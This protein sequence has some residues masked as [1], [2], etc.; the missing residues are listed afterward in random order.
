MFSNKHLPA[1]LLGLLVGTSPALEAQIS[2]PTFMAPR[3][4]N[5][6]GAYL[7]NPGLGQLAIEGIWRRNQGSYD[8]GLRGGLVDT[9]DDAAVTLGIEF[10]NPFVLGE[11]PV[12][13][14]LTAGAQGLIGD[15]QR[16]GAQVG[17]SVGATFYPEG[18]PFSLTPYL[19]PRLAVVS[20]LRDGDGTDVNVLADLGVDFEFAPNVSLRLG[21][22]V[23]DESSSFGFGFAVR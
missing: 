3:S 23:G 8:L 19:H 18:A 20:G 11:P 16:I 10:R 17:L 5:D 12:V 15:F 7:S 14:A 9:S 6:V 4:S 2:T 13:A 1:L 22:G 21:F